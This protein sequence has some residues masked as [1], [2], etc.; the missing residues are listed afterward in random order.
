MKLLVSL[1][2]QWIMRQ[3]AK[4]HVRMQ[5]PQSEREVEA[6]EAWLHA[7]PSHPS[8]YADIET[9]M[10][11]GERASRAKPSVAS[12]RLPPALAI[13]IIAAL[14]MCSTLLLAFPA[15]TPAIAA[16]TNDGPA[17]KTVSLADGS[18]LLLDIGAQLGL[19]TD[20]RER[21][22]DI[23]AGRVRTE[24]NPSQHYPL[25]IV[26]P[27]GNV[28]LHRGILDVTV[29][30]RAG[31]LSAVDGPVVIT[32]EA[33]A[34]QLGDF[35]LDGGETIRWNATGLDRAQTL[36]SERNWPDARRA[37]DQASLA[38]VAALANRHGSPPIVIVDDEVALLRISGVFDVRKTRPLATRLAATFNLATIEKSDRILLSRAR[39][40]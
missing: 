18:A 12:R 35:V 13:A 26:T 33:S 24:V 10:R 17:V 6:F 1:R 15:N 36:P 7:D 30:N 2:R 5:H 20:Q 3:A 29:E 27:A 32:F 8:A 22:I 11:S 34:E 25:Q 9:L 14:I 23:R 38:E 37:F 16:V 40:H 28:R 19:P 4:W 21:R 39:K 31:S